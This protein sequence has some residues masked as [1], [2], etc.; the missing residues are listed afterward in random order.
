MVELIDFD[1]T[2][3]KSAIEFFPAASR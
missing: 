1:V 2:V 3:T